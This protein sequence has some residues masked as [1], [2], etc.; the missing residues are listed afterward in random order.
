MR[1][2]TVVSHAFREEKQRDTYRKKKIMAVPPMARRT[3]IACPEQLGAIS[4]SLVS[5]HPGAHATHGNPSRENPDEF[6]E[7]HPIS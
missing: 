3:A 6:D 2:V 7:L 1:P 5:L 4:P